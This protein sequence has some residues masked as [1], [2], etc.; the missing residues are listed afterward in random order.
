MGVH[1]RGKDEHRYK[2]QTISHRKERKPQHSSPTSS[3]ATPRSVLTYTAYICLVTT[4]VLGIRLSHR[5][6]NISCSTVHASTP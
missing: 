2:I 5:P 4:S 3:W 6:S 1:Q